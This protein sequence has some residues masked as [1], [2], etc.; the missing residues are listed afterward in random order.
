MWMLLAEATMKA[1]EAAG[2]AVVPLKATEEM[3]KASQTA[4]G[5]SINHPYRNITNAAIAKGNILDR[6]EAEDGK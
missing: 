1:E 6:M 4:V 5:Y 3:V 2:L